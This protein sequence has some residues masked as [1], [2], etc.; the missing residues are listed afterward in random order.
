[1]RKR[2]GSVRARGE[3]SFQIRYVN[4]EGIRQQE[5]IKGERADAERELAVRLGEIAKGLDVSSRPNTV[6]FGELA[7]DVL[8]D[9][10]VNGFT[11]IDDQEARFRLHLLDVF[12]QRKASQITTAQIKKYIQKRQAEGAACGT[13]NR[14]LELMRHT[15]NLALEGRK[16]VV[17]PHVP[18]LRE[19]NVRTGFFTAEE[20]DRLASF[21]PETIAS[22]VRFAFWTGWRLGEIRKLEWRSVDFARGEIRLDPGRTKNREGRVFP[23]SVD[24]RNLLQAIEPARS[25]KP[26]RGNVVDSAMAAGA[27]RVFPAG[28][29]RKTWKTACHKAGLPCIVEPVRKGG[30]PGAVKVIKA[31]RTFHDLRRSFAREMD[32]KGMRRGAIKKLAGWITD[33]VFDRYNIVSDAD[34]RTEIERIDEAKRAGKRAGEPNA[35]RRGRLKPA[36]GKGPRGDSNA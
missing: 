34:L 16:L 35:V 1:M 19:D 22:M 9:Y 25:T 6:R 15:F 14:E 32:S 5:T 26:R 18:M 10:E 3:R 30:K 4:A 20:V 17:A 28:D 13:I 11:S 36:P 31:L 7:D 27:R 12:G 29:F 2:T 24:L 33:S 23:M 21:L 8:T